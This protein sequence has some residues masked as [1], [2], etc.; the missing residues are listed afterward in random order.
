MY[1]RPRSASS[2]QHRHTAG[3]ARIGP[4]HD[5]SRL[6]WPVAAADNYWHSNVDYSIQLDSGYSSPAD[7]R[8]RSI[9]RDKIQPRVINGV[10]SRAHKQYTRVHTPPPSQYA[11][12]DMPDGR[13]LP[14]QMQ[15]HHNN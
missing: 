5:Y 10:V 1:Y 15:V 11:I 2:E 13:K 12:I 8:S 7:A 9:V 3:G 6:G 14:V 4:D